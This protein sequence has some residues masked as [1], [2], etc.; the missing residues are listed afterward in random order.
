MKT[1]LHIRLTSMI[2]LSLFLCTSTVLTPP[3]LA[4]E[5]LLPDSIFLEGIEDSNDER[6]REDMLNHMWK[7][8]GAQGGTAEV[9]ITPSPTAVDAANPVFR[10]TGNGEVAQ[11]RDDLLKNL[12]LRA[13]RIWK[14]VHW[15]R[16][17]ENAARAQASEKANIAI[18]GLTEIARGKEKE[19]QSNE[20][21]PVLIEA[22]NL[23]TK[24][25]DPREAEPILSRVD[26]AKKLA[27]GLLETNSP[28][29]YKSIAAALSKE[30]Q[31]YDESFST[32][33]MRI[34]NSAVVSSSSDPYAASYA[35]SALLDK[36]LSMRVT[37][38]QT[39]LLG[40]LK[41]LERDIWKISESDKIDQI[42]RLGSSTE[43]K[44]GEDGIK[45]TISPDDIIKKFP[46]IEKIIQ[47][48]TADDPLEASPGSGSEATDPI[49]VLVGTPLAVPTPLLAPLAS[50]SFSG[51]SAIDSF[52]QTSTVSGI[53][54]DDIVAS[55]SGEARH[56]TATEGSPGTSLA[57]FEE[58]QAENTTL[59]YAVRGTSV[60]DAGENTL[61]F[62]MLDR[63][64]MSQ[65]GG[66][67]DPKDGF[68][69][70]AMWRDDETGA[71]DI[72]KL[73][74]SLRELGY[75]LG[76]V[77]EGRGVQHINDDN[78]HVPVFNRGLIMET[79]S[80]IKQ[81]VPEGI[82]DSIYLD[83]MADVINAYQA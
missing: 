39:Y 17:D 69:G 30:R 54:A 79:Q 35:L 47:Q 45:Q 38:I 74:R 32:E 31:S 36:G 22:L 4:Q 52:A 10:L 64:E 33:A 80:F 50:S 34:L 67:L 56:Y 81:Y 19:G 20:A 37:Q 12:G 48:F 25:K 21:I 18:E 1:R 27:E 72:A 60:R 29:A 77:V 68:L 63:D 65:A 73:Q 7:L 26:F 11:L 61:P 46:E 28:K 62:L 43:E 16:R 57:S 3:S 8:Y 24:E 40:I 23:I 41:H 42:N 76:L 44:V 82:F 55:V 66:S 71:V 14:L 13:T 49:N 75:N 78:T 5:Y 9:A 53:S 58:A 15:V 59:V 83:A 6:D 70:P 51:P 2:T